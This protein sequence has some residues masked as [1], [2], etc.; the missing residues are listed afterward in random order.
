M[1]VGVVAGCCDFP[2]ACF[3]VD[4][5][6]VEEEEDTFE[7][8]TR[9]IIAVSLL[10]MACRGIL[11]IVDVVFTKGVWVGADDGAATVGIEEEEG[12]W[13]CGFFLRAVRS[14]GFSICVDE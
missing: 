10:L 14:V 4:T 8:M 9:F 13:C 7:F 1:V 3:C 5:K 6:L 12:F 2:Q 11:R